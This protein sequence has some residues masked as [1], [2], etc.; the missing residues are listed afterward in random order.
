MSDYITKKQVIDLLYYYED[1]SC[2]SVVLDAEALIAADV[3]PVVHSRW[4][5]VWGDGY[6]EDS[7]GIPR[8][9]YEIFECSNCGCEHQADGEP[10]WKYCPECGALM[11]GEE[12]VK[13]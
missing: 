13:Y 2:A 7:E 6:A 10:E 3:S 5:G 9:V 8:I 11:D 1:E 4:V 12:N